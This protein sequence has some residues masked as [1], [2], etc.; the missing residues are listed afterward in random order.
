MSHAGREA[1]ELRHDG[2]QVHGLA[3]FS[4]GISHLALSSYD[5]CAHGVASSLELLQI[6]RADLVSVHQSLEATLVDSRTTS[7]FIATFAKLR[8]DAVAAAAA[9][10]FFEHS[11][12]ILASVEI[13]CQTQA[14][15]CSTRTC[16][17]RHTRPPK[18]VGPADTAVVSSDRRPSQRIRHRLAVEQRGTQTVSP[19]AELFAPRRS[20]GDRCLLRAS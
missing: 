11:R 13:D 17:F 16:G 10:P 20:S 2:S 7:G 19:L 14:S 9:R 8:W 12:R 4:I 1:L 5:P 6:D 15:S 3:K 18:S